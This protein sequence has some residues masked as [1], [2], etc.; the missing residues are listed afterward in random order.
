MSPGMW[1]NWIDER[2]A[3]YRK[4]SF[5]VPDGTQ[6]RPLYDCHFPS[7]WRAML[8]PTI[9]SIPEWNRVDA[10]LRNVMAAV[11]LI[12]PMATPVSAALA[13][14]PE[15]VRFVT[16]I[17]AAQDWASIARA[18]LVYGPT[19]FKMCEL[20]A[21]PNV[22]GGPIADLVAACLES[23]TAFATLVANGELARSPIMLSLGKHIKSTFGQDQ[24]DMVVGYWRSAEFNMPPHFMHAF[25]QQ[26][27]QA[28]LP[29]RL[30]ALEDLTIRP[31]SVTEKGR[32]VPLLYR[33]FWE[34]DGRSEDLLHRLRTLLQA[35]ENGAISVVGN[36]TGNLTFGKLAIAWASGAADEGNLPPELAASVHR[37]VPW[38]RVVAVEGITDES[39]HPVSNLLPY[40]IAHRSDLVLK[41]AFGFDARDVTVGKDVEPAMWLS[42]VHT[43]VSSAAPWIV[44]RY[45]ETQSTDA[46]VSA[47]GQVVRASGMSIFGAFMFGRRLAGMVER[48]SYEGKSSR[49]SVPAGA[50]QC[51]VYV[52]G[53]DAGIVRA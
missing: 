1:M 46:W 52:G 45:I 13:L 4:R 10:D 12:N 31:D 5:T 32:L 38:T 33:F 29:T 8:T 18:D 44:Q 21:G 6:M 48:Y 9:V 16:Q 41:P 15:P 19:G 26:L 7:G 22:G 11:D 3:D 20:N 43:A 30:S 39:G 34:T 17:A 36:F 42:A 35:E 53:Q 2:S 23:E 28:G 40:L 47:D 50:A 27:S 14:V 25:C 49:V 24:E 37:L 51:A